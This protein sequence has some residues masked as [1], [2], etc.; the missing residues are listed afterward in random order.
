[1]NEITDLLTK[2]SSPSES[3][4]VTIHLLGGFPV[5]SDEDLEDLFSSLDVLHNSKL[6]MNVETFCVGAN[7]VSTLSTHRVP[8]SHGAMCT[9]QLAGE[10]DFTPILLSPDARGPDVILRFSFPL[11]GYVLVHITYISMCTCM[12]TCMCTCMCAALPTKLYNRYSIPLTSH[13]CII[14]VTSL[15]PHQLL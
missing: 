8:F 9:I 11:L 1:M 14:L 5:K 15:T 7:N 6:Q 13:M 4:V 10:S 12:F 2:E 3:P